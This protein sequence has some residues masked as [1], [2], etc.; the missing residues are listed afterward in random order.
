MVQRLI[1]EQLVAAT[2]AAAQIL[3]ERELFRDEVGKVLWLDLADVENWLVVWDELGLNKS[4]VRGVQ[5]IVQRR[6]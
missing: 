2:V 1:G 5:L 3:L 4:A 6:H